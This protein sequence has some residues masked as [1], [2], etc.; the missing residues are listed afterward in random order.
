MKENIIREL[1]KD[2]KPRDIKNLS[3]KIKDLLINLD[4]PKSEWE[5]Y[6]GLSGKLPERYRR[7]KAELVK[8]G[9]IVNENKDSSEFE[10]FFPENVKIRNSLYLSCLSKCTSSLQTNVNIS[11]GKNS[12]GTVMIGSPVPKLFS[13]FYP[14]SEININLDEGSIGDVVIMFSFD[15]ETSSRTKINL[16]VG[17]NAILNFVTV[18]FSSGKDMGLEVNAKQF[19]NSQ[20][21]FDEV[22]FMLEENSYKG[23]VANVD[24]FGKKSFLKMENADFSF[25]QGISKTAYFANVKKGAKGSQTDL[26]S[27]GLDFSQGAEKLFL[28]GLYTEEDDVSLEHGAGNAQMSEE[29]I[30]FLKA[31]GLSEKDIMTLI[32][33]STLER[34]VYNRL[35]DKFLLEMKNF[36]KYILKSG[37]YIL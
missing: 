30:E 11:F 9:L 7:I 23:T 10:V 22:S 27:F 5:F 35:P 37:N 14:K 13:S 31:R 25:Q 34:T 29:K 21:F 4:I 18:T 32:I 1:V 16:N 3:E 17:K 24:I 12:K 2:T 33:E 15:N 36:S 20:L 26:R 8:K 28:P 19:D 6:V